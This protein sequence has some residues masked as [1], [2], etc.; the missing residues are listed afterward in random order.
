MPVVPLTP[1]NFSDSDRCSIFFEIEHQVVAPQ[2]RALADGRRLRR[3]QVRHSQAGKV[4]ILLGEACENVD[5]L[6]KPAADEVDR[7]ANLN[8]I[9]VVGDFAR[10]RAEMDDAAGTGALIAIGVDVRHDVVTQL[11]FVFRRDGE[12]DLVD[13]RPQF[14]DLGFGDI[15][16]EFV[17]RLSESD[18]DAAQVECLAWSDQR[19]LISF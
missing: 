10:R 12:I 18:P 8:E 9:G 6:H 19:P 5:D 13:V 16:A 3:L 11:A 15:E 7:F 17:L 14:L 2:R 1:R 4:A